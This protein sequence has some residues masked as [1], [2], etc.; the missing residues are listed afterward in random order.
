MIPLPFASGGASGSRTGKC[1]NSQ[2]LAEVGVHPLAIGQ[3]SASA[4]KRRGRPDQPTAFSKDDEEQVPPSSGRH[5][6]RPHEDEDEGI[7][8]LI[9]RALIKVLIIERGR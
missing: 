9:I 7:D 1:K 6:R 5:G 8:K 3:A 2:R 4:I